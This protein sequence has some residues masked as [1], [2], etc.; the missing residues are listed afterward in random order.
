MKKNLSFII[1]LSFTFLSLAGCKKTNEIT[2][3]L[4]APLNQPP[5]DMTIVYTATQTGDGVIASLS[6]VTISGTI[7]VQNP[8]LPWTITVP[9]FTS[10]KVTISATGTTKNGSLSISYDG[11]S[12]GSTIHGSD[13]CEQQ[14]N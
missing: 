10:T 13:S 5:V 11:N 9:V 8:Q 1:F 14:T 7:T 4:S 2:C 3:A 6:Y 12:G